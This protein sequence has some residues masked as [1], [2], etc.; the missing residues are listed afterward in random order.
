MPYFYVHEDKFILYEHNPGM[1]IGG[2]DLNTQAST[3][4]PLPLPS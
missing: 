3:R 1:I 4:H 2:L